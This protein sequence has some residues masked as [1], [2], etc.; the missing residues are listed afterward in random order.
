MK[1]FLISAL[2]LFAP[3]ANAAEPLP[4]GCERQTV[5]RLINGQIVYSSMVVCESEEAS[6]EE[7][8]VDE[9]S[10]DV[11]PKLRRA[12]AR[13]FNSSRSNRGS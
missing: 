5:S 6:V 1:P 4:D 10:V 3:V 12:P 11:T 8:R 13:N 7:P 2:L 9:P